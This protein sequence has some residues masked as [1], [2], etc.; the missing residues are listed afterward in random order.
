[1]TSIVVPASDPKASEVFFLVNNMQAEPVYVDELLRNLVPGAP[2]LLLWGEADPWIVPSRVRSGGN[3]AQ[4]QQEG[5]DLTV[6]ATS[7]LSSAC[8]TMFFHPPSALL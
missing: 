1:M 5:L 7:F 6:S 3:P 4:T 8:Y 2:L